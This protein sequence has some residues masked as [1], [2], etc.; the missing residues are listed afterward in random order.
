MKRGEELP[1]ASHWKEGKVTDIVLVE[2]ATSKYR[3][4][5]GK[6]KKV[7]QLS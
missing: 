4:G 6:K 7:Q 1:C 5:A 2:N 3:I